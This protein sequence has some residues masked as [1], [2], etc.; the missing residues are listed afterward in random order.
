MCCRSTSASVLAGARP[1]FV[2][3]QGQVFGANLLTAADEYGALDGV[4]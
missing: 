1:R 2:H 3:Q 4:L